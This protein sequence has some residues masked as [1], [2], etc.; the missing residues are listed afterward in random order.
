MTMEPTVIFIWIIHI[1]ARHVIGTAAAAAAAAAAANQSETSSVVQLAFIVPEDTSWLFCRQRIRPAIE[2]AQAV[3]RRQQL[4]SYTVFNVRYEDSKCDSV[5][6]PLAAF[7]FFHERQVDVFMGPVCDYSLAPVARYAPY[8]NIPV[9]TPG[10]MAHDF[11]ANKSAPNAEYALLTR[12]GWTFDTLSQ[13]VY[14]TIKHYGWSRIKLMY[15]STGHGQVT[16]KFCYLFMNGLINLLRD[17][18][19]SDLYF[20]VSMFNNQGKLPGE[21]RQKL[22][23]EI[24]NEFAGCVYLL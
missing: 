9:I 10:G 11:G 23:E 18:A 5:T 8:W 19:T 15:N 7:N 24:A 3:I 13:S 14:R 21:I 6:A 4:L 2:A 1:S 22:A 12:V 20:H 16:D 17:D